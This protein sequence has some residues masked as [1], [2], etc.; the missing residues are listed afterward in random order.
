MELFGVKPGAFQGGRVNSCGSLWYVVCEMVR[1][2]VR[3]Q[4]GNGRDLDKAQTGEATGVPRLP[5]Q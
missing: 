4:V 2:I 3:A 1:A 5:S